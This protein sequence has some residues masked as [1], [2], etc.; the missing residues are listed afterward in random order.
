MGLP[1]AHV[2]QSRIQASM[3]LTVADLIPRWR[4]TEPAEPPMMDDTLPDEAPHD[5]PRSLRDL[6]EQVVGNAANLT[7]PQQR[8]VKGQLSRLATVSPTEVLAPVKAVT[9]GRPSL[10]QKRP[11]S[12]TRRD[13]SAFEHVEG[14]R[15]KYR[16]RSCGENGIMRERVQKT[17]SEMV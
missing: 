17:V 2:I 3:T 1:C 5:P 16:C 8:D 11:A 13:P 14:K 7:L 10:S 12:S 6:V 15:K 4:L 9:R